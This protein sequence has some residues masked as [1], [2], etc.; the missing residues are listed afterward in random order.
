MNENKDRPAILGG[1]AIRPQGP[2]DWPQHL[3]EV[4]ER[5]QEA[6]RDGSWGKYHGPHVAELA[7]LLAADHDCEHVVLCASG[8]AAIELALRGVGVGDGDE[9]L[10]SA[11]DFKANFQDVLVLGAM[12]VLVDVSSGTWLLDPASLEA[13]VGPRTR[14]I[15]VSHLHGAIA[16]LPRVV[17]LARARGLAVIEDAAQ[18]PG[19]RVYGRMAGMWG[20]A[21]VLSFGGSK[22]VS[23]GRGGAVLTA[24]ADVA[25][26][27]KLFTQRGN[28]AY[29]LS[30]LQAA[31]V[32]PQ[33]KR[34][35]VANER[36]ARSANLLIKEL[37][38]F[39]GLQPPAD[40]MADSLPAYYKLGFLYDAREFAGLP[41]DGFAAA[42]RAEGI[43]FDPGFRALHKT[44][45]SRRFRAV[46]DLPH[47]TR[48]DEAV[49]TLHHP[50]LSEADADVQEIVAA[51]EKVSRHAEEIGAQFAASAISLSPQV[52]D[53]R[54]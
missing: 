42:L 52:G 7:G 50:V 13:A 29:P 4:A 53:S 36:R 3:P 10:L 40:G 48:A 47:A 19:A 28:D 12:P 39:A 38:P 11:Y 5:I 17:E 44:H 14:A 21:G 23:A 16:N 32:I 22:L 8:T 20:D 46:G 24:R 51:V 37:R 15:V 34:L 9:V 49:L 30:E 26:R 35:A 2:P 27:I 43:A 31:A 54:T 6:L 25:Q 1:R 18:M 33:W 45:S 41:R